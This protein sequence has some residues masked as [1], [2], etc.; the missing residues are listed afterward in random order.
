MSNNEILINKKHLSKSIYY[1]INDFIS[2]DPLILNEPNYIDIIS[3]NIIELLSIQFEN[4]IELKFNFVLN[5]GDIINDIN[6]IIKECFSHYHRKKCPIRSFKTTFIIN[7]PNVE[8][9][10][11]KINYIKSKPQP[12][13]KSKEWYQTR[14]GL[15][16][17]SSIWKAFGS[18]SIKNQLIYDKCNDFNIEK[19]NKVNME[20]TLHWG[21]KYEPLSV[22]I[23]ES[24]Y[25][26]SVSDFGCIIHD[27]YSY[28]AASPDGIN[29]DKSSLRYGRMLEIKNIVNR[30]ITGEIKHEYW[31]Q[32]Q[33]QMEVCNLNECDFLETR[34][35]EYQTEEDFY[36]DSNNF[37]QEPFIYTKNLELKGIIM[38]FMVDNKPYYEYPQLFITKEDFEEW[39]ISIMEKHERENNIWIKNIYWKL[40][41][42]NCV[43]VLRNKMWFNSA[44]KKIKEIWDTICREKNNDF[45]HRAPKKRT[46]KQETDDIDKNNKKIKEKNYDKK[47]EC[48]IDIN[49]LNRQEEINDINMNEAKETNELIIQIETQ[50]NNTDTYE[51]MDV[52]IYNLEIE[53]IHVELDIINNK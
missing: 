47:N 9:I 29:T 30:E 43:L 51:C 31:I 25:N 7:P 41:E 33:I 44:I 49:T 8:K 52:D 14:H 36:N 12:E 50:I 3:E 42:F 45:E 35:I 53:N 34:F 46:I 39:E 26:T 13:Q 24:F 1:L 11:K 28:L 16:T 4:L 17:A 27:K 32:T 40:D 10:N 22:K 5:N 19:Y 38:C 15:L 23:Y 6:N 20:S 37:S 48:F 21:H 18:E 2:Q